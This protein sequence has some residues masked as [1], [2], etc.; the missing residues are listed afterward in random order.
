MEKGHNYTTN[1]P[2]CIIISKN[3]DLE[4]I[5]AYAKLKKILQTN[6]NYERAITPLLSVWF[7]WLLK[8]IEIVWI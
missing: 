8:G 3:Q 6:F 5:K 7:V 2:I 4:D 1:Y